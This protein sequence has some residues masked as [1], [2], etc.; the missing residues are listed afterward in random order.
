VFLDHKYKESVTYEWEHRNTVNSTATAISTTN[1]KLYTTVDLETLG[2]VAGNVSLTIKGESI[3]GTDGD[4]NTGNVFGGGDQSAVTQSIVNGNPVPNT[5]NTTVNLQEGAHVLGNVYG[6]GNEGPV[7][8]DSK[9]IIEDAPT[10][11][12]TTPFTGTTEVT[13]TGPTGSEI[14]YTIDGS[15][16]T[17]SSTLYSS[18]FSLNATT[19]VK[20]I[21]ITNGVAGPVAT[22]TFTKQ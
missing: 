7:G 12:G 21:A 22:K 19:T 11:S 4:S 3:I 17:A 10:I 6:G 2:T 16:P 18:S 9:V 5:G 1:K 14:H 15:T 20:A 13:I 8:G